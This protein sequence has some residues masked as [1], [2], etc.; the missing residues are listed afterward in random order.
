MSEGTNIAI[1]LDNMVYI[2]TTTGYL[3]SHTICFYNSNI[4]TEY[5]FTVCKLVDF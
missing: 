2:I 5:R 1:V 3:T 4:K